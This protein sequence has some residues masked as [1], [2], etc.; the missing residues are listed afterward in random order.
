MNLF[1][2]EDPF[3]ELFGKVIVGMI[4]ALVALTTIISFNPVASTTTGTVSQINV[5]FGFTNINF[6]ST[7]TSIG[8]WGTHFNIRIGEQIQVYRPSWQFNACQIIEIG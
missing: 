1:D 5:S 8:C 4:I 6:I 3:I 7:S 2:K